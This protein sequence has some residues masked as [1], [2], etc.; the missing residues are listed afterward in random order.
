MENN[1]FAL[2]GNREML[3]KERTELLLVDLKNES[4]KWEKIKLSGKSF[5]IESAEYLSQIL[6]ALVNVT[7]VDI[8]DIIAG[9]SKEEANRVLQIICDALKDNSKIVEVDIS[10]NALGEKGIESC[11]NLLSK[12]ET[13][14]S[15]TLN[16]DGLSPAAAKLLKGVLLRG[17][18]NIALKKLHFF[19][20]LLKDGGAKEIS[21]II[22][23]CPNLTDFRFSS[24]RSGI[25][26]ILSLTNSLISCN[27]L[28]ALDLSDNSA[29]SGEGN[30]K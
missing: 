14:E 3:S 12:T 22:N 27:Q 19:N 23:S 16:N 9:K 2:E 26:G 4:T 8:S 1:T 6:P 5:N 13:I 21:E 10:D 29:D 25:D 18:K 7:S 30:K 20:N 17:N 28:V 11:S 15:L 24:T